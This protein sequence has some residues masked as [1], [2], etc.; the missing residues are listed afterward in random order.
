[1]ITSE[2]ETWSREMPFDAIE[3]GIMSSD[4]ESLIAYLEDI[5]DYQ[6][7]SGTTRL[8]MRDILHR[9]TTHIQ[10]SALP[11]SLRY[12][13]ADLMLRRLFYSLQALGE[14]PRDRE[15]ARSRFRLFV[16]VDEA[17][18]LVSQKAGQKQVIKAVLNKYATEM[19]KFGVGLI[20]ASQLISH[21]ND[22]ILANIA[23]KFCMRTEN[24]KQAMENSR[25]FEISESDLM[26]FAPGEGIIAAGSRR[27]KL[28]VLPLSRRR[29]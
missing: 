18:L 23:V 27:T 6:L 28:K 16:V 25:Y 10:L 21:F 8:S 11:E 5:F 20:L 14:I 12:L 4:D 17:K 7:F 22:E 29:S 24:R 1:G 26:N 19:R 13:F 2:L 9:G 3:E 15:D